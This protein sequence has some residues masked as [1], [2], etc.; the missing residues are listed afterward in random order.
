[1]THLW[2]DRK[3]LYWILSSKNNDS[4]IPTPELVW[5]HF[6]SSVFY[7]ADTELLLNIR[8]YKCYSFH[9]LFHLQCVF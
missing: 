6:F 1:M 2:R 7:L 5:T 8:L 9:I 4:L 3:V